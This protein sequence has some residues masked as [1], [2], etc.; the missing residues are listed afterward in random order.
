M[1]KSPPT[2]SVASCNKV[3]STQHSLTATQCERR[4]KWKC[5]ARTPGRAPPGP[6]PAP[7]PYE[8]SWPAYQPT[9][10]AAYK[11]GMNAKV[12]DPH[13][14]LMANKSGT[15][16]VSF[17]RLNNASL[18]NTGDAW[19]TACPTCPLASSWY[20]GCTCATP[21]AYRNHSWHTAAVQWGTG[22]HNL[23]H[24]T[25]A[26]RASIRLHGTQRPAALSKR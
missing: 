6:A 2:H 22:T 15:I 13:S 14:Q 12:S 10:T 19:T 26:P 4:L 25:R 11:A 17:C 7:H 8:V 5:G 24:A 21:I 18:S 23:V 3:T 16:Y 1:L 20:L 9:Q